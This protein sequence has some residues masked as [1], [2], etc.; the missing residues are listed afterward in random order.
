METPT[1][2]AVIGCM[3]GTAVGDAIGLPSERLSPRRQRRMFS[4]ID[5][6][7]LFFGR[8]MTSDDTEHTASWPT[9]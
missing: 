2:D 1:A 3:L 8:G 4:H 9:L 6:H 5:S 7:R